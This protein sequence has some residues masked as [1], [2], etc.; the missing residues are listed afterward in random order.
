MKTQIFLLI[1]N[2]VNKCHAYNQI[3]KNNN[4]FE[5]NFSMFPSKKGYGFTETPACT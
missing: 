4:N 2:K 5:K 3:K 1:I